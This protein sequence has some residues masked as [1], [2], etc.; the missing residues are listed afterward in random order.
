MTLAIELARVPL[1]ER[2]LE[3][4]RAGVV[5]GGSKKNRAALADVVSVRAGVDAALATL[6][7][8]FGAEQ[9][10]FVD[11]FF[12]EPFAES[13]FMPRQVFVHNPLPQAEKAVEIFHSDRQILAFI[14]KLL[15]EF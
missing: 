5:S 2:A 11:D 8:E 15:Q 7:F 14:R 1:L 13:L 4:A 10:D 9:A 3:F 6:G 12:V